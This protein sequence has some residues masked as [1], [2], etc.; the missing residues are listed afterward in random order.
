MDRIFPRGFSL[1]E[2]LVVAV[3]VAL[4]GL[5][6][7]PAFG[8]LI[9]RQRATTLADQL[10]AHLH[11]ARA[12]S[13]TRNADVEFCGSSNGTD[14][15]QGW[16]H[17]WIVRLRGSG[18]TLRYHQLTPQDH[19]RW[20]RGETILFRSNG[21]AP[22]G[23]GRFYVCDREAAVVWQLVLNRQGRVRRVAGLEASQAS[24]G[25]YCPSA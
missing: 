19:L 13:V 24:D 18:E 6:A 21:T 3:L 9:E 14:C 2:L 17:G 7:L 20:T 10:Q 16:Q 23:N 4:L 12:S 5:F 1:I 15:D 11:F 22:L 25:R 8:T